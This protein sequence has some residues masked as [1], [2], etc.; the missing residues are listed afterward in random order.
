MVGWRWKAQEDS[1]NDTVISEQQPCRGE[2]AS[3]G[4]A[5]K[6]VPVPGAVPGMES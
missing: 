3:H 2:G 6:G 4:V 5:R 1:I